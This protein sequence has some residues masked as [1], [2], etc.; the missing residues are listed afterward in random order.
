VAKIGVWLLL[1]GCII[2]EAPRKDHWIMIM[3]V[4]ASGYSDSESE[5]VYS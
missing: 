5:S 3:R 2:K 4:S 1:A